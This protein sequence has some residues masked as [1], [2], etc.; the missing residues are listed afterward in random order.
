MIGVSA[1]QGVWLVQ[2]YL[3]SIGG[4]LTA[5]NFRRRYDKVSHGPGSSKIPFALRD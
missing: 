2:F 4:L 5:S 3:T 1:V